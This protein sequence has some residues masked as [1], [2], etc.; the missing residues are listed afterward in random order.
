MKKP[1][2]DERQVLAR[3]Q[4]YKYGFWAGILYF[5]LA[6]I[7]L[8]KESLNFTAEEAMLY[9]AVIMLLVF[10]A[11]AIWKDAYFKVNDQGTLGSG[12]LVAMGISNLIRYWGEAAFGVFLAL[13][14]IFLGTLIF[15][16]S[17]LNHDERET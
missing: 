8:M 15:L 16:R 4:A 9:G 2:F 17:M 5:F 1:H 11:V 10:F 3:G 6:S 14:M 7:A 13:G 12:F